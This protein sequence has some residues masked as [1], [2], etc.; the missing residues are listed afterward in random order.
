MSEIRHRMWLFHNSFYL[1]SK[2]FWILW[3]VHLKST[4]IFKWSTHI[5]KWIHLH[6]FIPRCEP[7]NVAYMWYRP[8]ALWLVK[9]NWCVGLFID[10][11]IDLL[12]VP[13][14]NMPIF[15]R[16]AENESHL[17][18]KGNINTNKIT[19]RI[20]VWFDW[21]AYGLSYIQS[22]A[23]ITRSNITRSCM[24]CCRERCEI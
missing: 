17:I 24:C 14:L 16:L 15:H 4:H 18:Y 21:H 8:K 20:V 23:V 22:S 3:R 11:C 9:G 1:I 7:W 2:K 6:L 10:Y 13:Y 12:G 19:N 5:F